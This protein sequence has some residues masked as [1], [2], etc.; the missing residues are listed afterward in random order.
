MIRLPGNDTC[1]QGFKSEYEGFIMANFYNQWAGEY[2]CV[3]K[4]PVKGTGSINH[5][6]GR[7]LLFQ[8]YCNIICLHPRVVRIYPTEFVCGNLPCGQYPTGHEVACVVCSPEGPLSGSSYVRW[9]RADCPSSSQFVYSGRA[10]GSEHNQHGSGAN[11]LCVID[12][13]SFPYLQ[14]GTQGGGRLRGFRYVTNGYGIQSLVAS[15]NF[16]VPCAVCFTPERESN[17]MQ[18]GRDDCPVDWE[19]QYSGYLFGSHYSHRKTNFICIDKAAQ[20][21]ESV[22]ND[23]NIYPTEVECGSIR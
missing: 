12:L 22:S 5:N 3:D 20:S 9:G 14:P 1:P 16:A 18:P 23:V 10:A 15:N 21:L 2:I 19:V 4:N 7:Y 13:P 8:S 6:N 11:P 17:F